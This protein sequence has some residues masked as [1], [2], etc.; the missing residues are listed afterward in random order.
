MAV[1]GDKFL[2]LSKA[3][4]FTIREHALDRVLQHTGLLPTR[5]LAFALFDRSRQ[6]K[7]A[8]MILLGYRPAYS[9]RKR[10]GKSSWYFRFHLFAKELIAVVQKGS[11]PGEYVWVTTYGLTAQNINLRIETRPV[12]AA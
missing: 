2:I 11:E 10:R 7:V 12:L 9:R 3:H 8:D 6:L 1:H 5:A 4:A